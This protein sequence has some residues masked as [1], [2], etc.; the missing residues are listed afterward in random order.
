[1]ILFSQYKC[2][3]INKLKIIMIICINIEFSM[4]RNSDIFEYVL[5]ILLY[6]IINNIT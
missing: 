6:S 2:C 5:I 4:F 3:Y 1:M